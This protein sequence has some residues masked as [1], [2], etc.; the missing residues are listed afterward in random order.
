MSTR[1]TRSAIATVL[2]ES[3]GEGSVDL[4]VP[5]VYDELRTMARRQMARERA[6]HT[7][8]TVALV[9]EA[10][11][12]LAGDELAAEKGRTYF[13]GAAARAMRR[14]LVEHARARQR[15]KRGGDWQRITLATGLAH[16]DSAAELLELESAI[17]SLAD[18]A[19]RQARVVEYRYFGGMSVA[20]TATALA[21]SPRTVKSDWALARAWLYRALHG[22]A[23]R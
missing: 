8:C 5:V 11:L 10:Y 21:I 3:H 23:P 12:R 6:G 4:L 13:F 18:I 14:I 15:E 17:E 7:L 1:Q 20:D 2:H 22:E 16:C 19:P 9:N